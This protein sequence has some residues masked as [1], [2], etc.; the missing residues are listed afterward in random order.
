MD[1]VARS[2][3]G[4]VEKW[5][6]SIV[7]VRALIGT[8]YGGYPLLVVFSK[9][10]KRKNSMLCGKLKGGDVLHVD[11]VVVTNIPARMDMLVL[12]R[13]DA[14]SINRGARKE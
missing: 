13:E 3:F 6:D 11:G 2:A 5:D 4:S 10:G 14:S 9:I 8:L 1:T 7:I 12:F